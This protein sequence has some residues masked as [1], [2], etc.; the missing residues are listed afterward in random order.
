MCDPEAPAFVRQERVH[1]VRALRGLNGVVG[2]PPVGEAPHESADGADPEVAFRVLGERADFDHALGVGGDAERD[3][4]ELAARD[5][6]R[7]EAEQPALRARPDVAVAVFEQH[8]HDVRL[9]VVADAVGLEDGARA[10]GVRPREGLAIARGGDAARVLRRVETRDAAAVGRHP[11][12]A[13][14]AALDQIVDGR[15]RQ[16]VPL[17]VV[18]EAVA[19]EARQPVERAEP[20]EAARVAH[21]ALHLIVRQPVGDRVPAD[22]QLFGARRGGRA[23][24]REREQHGARDE[25]RELVCSLDHGGVS[26]ASR[27]GPGSGVRLTRQGRSFAQ[28]PQRFNAVGRWAAGGR[29]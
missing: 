12:G 18:V 29:R 22:R 23:R 26:R 16:A 15:V 11:V 14:A 8:V 2:R 7:A 21:D 4:L 19:V 20:E 28:L 3:A 13:V 10:P 6:V 5:V 9:R 27:R 24:E 25:R 1:V 17:V